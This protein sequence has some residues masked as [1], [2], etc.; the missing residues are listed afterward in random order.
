MRWSTLSTGLAAWVPFVACVSIAGGDEPGMVDDAGAAYVRA[1]KDGVVEQ[2]PSGRVMLAYE[3]ASDS[4]RVRGAA[5]YYTV[6][7]GRQWTQ[8]A[9]RDPMANPIE[10]D[11]PADGLYGFWFVLH[12]E[13]GSTPPPVAGAAPHRWVM[14]DRSGPT[15][16]VRRLDASSEGGVREILIEWLATDESNNLGQRPV[17]VSYQ[18]G[19]AAWREIARGLAASGEHRWTVPVNVAGPLRLRVAAIDRAG[20]VGEVTTRDLFSAGPGVTEPAPLVRVNT[21]VSLASLRTPEASAK[22]TASTTDEQNSQTE[23]VISAYELMQDADGNMKQVDPDAAAAAKKEYDLGVWHRRRGDLATA[24]ERF[25]A[26]LTVSPDLAEARIELA[27]TL[28]ELKRF[29]EAIVEYE[30]VLARDSRNVSALAGL[31]LAQLQ[32]RAYASAYRTF[33]RLLRERPHDGE[34]WLHFG[35]VCMFMGDRRGAREA[36]HSAAEQRG[37][38]ASLKARAERRLAIYQ[39]DRLGVAD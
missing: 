32:A 6:D 15:I 35:D 28:H 27:G 23:V 22:N 29:D 36:W 7:L 21:T 20:N 5:L 37:A 13:T 3:V 1:L 17:V 31:A 19:A 9:L 12:G 33:D 26:A 18:S 25:R 24:M 14:V 30:R 4:P 38:T 2:V 34:A 11:A 8:A 16:A 10:F 39:R